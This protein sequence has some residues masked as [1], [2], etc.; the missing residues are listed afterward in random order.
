MTDPPVWVPMANGTM[1]SATPAAEP[2]EDPPGVN[3]GLWGLAVFPGF[4]QANSVVTVFPK[5]TAPAFLRK[6]TQDE[7][8]TG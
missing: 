6:L 5:I 1:K 8:V 3:S 7:S 4:L 2:L